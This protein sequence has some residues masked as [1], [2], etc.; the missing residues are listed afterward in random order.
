MRTRSTLTEVVFLLPQRLRLLDL[1]GPAEV[2]RTAVAHGLPYRLSFV[3]D[4]PDPVTAEG[5]AVRAGTEMPPL[6]PSDLVFVTGAVAGG[7]LD[8]L[9]RHH[10]RG[11]TVVGVGEGVDALGSSGLLDRRRCT[12]HHDLRRDLAKR[13][14]AT[15][16]V[17]DVLHV[18]DDRVATSAGTGCGIDLALHLI[19]LAHGASAAARVARAMVVYPRRNG[20][21][22]EPG[23]PLRYRGHVDDLA[24]RLQDLVEARFTE[25][26]RLIDMSRELGFS[27]RT[28]TRH[29]RRATG[30]TPLRYQQLLR[31]ERAELLIGRGATVDAAARAVGLTDAR[32]L[33]ALRVWSPLRL[34]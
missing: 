8:A 31:A 18:V 17:E 9:R 33:R 11:G 5:L 25:R 26:L 27:E 3:A 13:F 2:Y 15:T 16:V 1:A 30:M 19:G 21:E 22:P 32:A 6:T 29:F 14:P 10:E 20:D 4:E 23:V 12:A 28:L 24:H 7:A 34:R